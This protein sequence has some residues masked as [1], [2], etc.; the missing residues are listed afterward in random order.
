MSGQ[1][2]LTVWACGNPWLPV[3]KA[4]AFTC[5]LAKFRVA[6]SLQPGRTCQARDLVGREPS[7]RPASR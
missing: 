6:M 7:A 4:Q 1:A 2:T 3:F 5:H